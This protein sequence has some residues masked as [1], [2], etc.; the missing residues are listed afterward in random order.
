VYRSQKS[1]YFVATGLPRCD[2]VW[3]LLHP[4][5]FG[6]KSIS[7]ITMVEGDRVRVSSGDLQEIFELAKMD[8]RSCD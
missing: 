1:G 7:L 8:T 5:D 6:E 3:W 2:K 4:A